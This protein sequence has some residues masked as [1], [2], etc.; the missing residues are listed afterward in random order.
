MSIGEKI[1]NSRNKQGITQQE[2][3]TKLNVSRSA[4]SNWEVGRNYPDLDSIVLLSDM[5]GLT[6]DELLREDAVMVKAVGQEQRKNSKRK[7]IL[8]V[9]IPAFLISLVVIGL[10]ISEV[11]IVS[12]IF[13]P[14]FYGFSEI[15]EEQEWTP[16]SWST[17][18]GKDATTY[19]NVKGLFLE[20]EIVSL[21]GNESNLEVRISHPKTKEVFDQFFIDEASTEAINKLIKKQDY[22]VEIKGAVGRYT[23]NVY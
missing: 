18:D 12:D 8:L 23:L 13:T 7:R 11:K 22:L 17:F 2:L 4:V 20:K 9:L 5:L 3:A 15:D 19:L 10:L 21:T 6:L 1:K 14:N 16:V